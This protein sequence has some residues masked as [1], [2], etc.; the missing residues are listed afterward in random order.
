MTLSFVNQW[1]GGQTN[2]LGFRK[3]HPVGELPVE[4]SWGNLSREAAFSGCACENPIFGTES[5]TQVTVDMF[6]SLALTSLLNN[7]NGD[8]KGFCAD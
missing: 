2:L 3:T 6:I 4:Q 7:P 1:S 5:C 8:F